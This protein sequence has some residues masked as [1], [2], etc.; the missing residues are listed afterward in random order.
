MPFFLTIKT[1]N[2]II[3]KNLYMFFFKVI[4]ELKFLSYILSYVT[5]KNKFVSNT[6]NLLLKRKVFFY[7]KKIT[8]IHN[9][10]KQKILTSFHYSSIHAYH[11]FQT[12]CFF[13]LHYHCFVCQTYLTHCILASDILAGGTLFVLYRAGSK[14]WVALKIGLFAG[15]CCPVVGGIILILYVV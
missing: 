12:I 6:F 10:Y 5:Y 15:C 11:C 7:I 3:N 1:S 4:S 14:N 2:L 8:K 9:E 13:L